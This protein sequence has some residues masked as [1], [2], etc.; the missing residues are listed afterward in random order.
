M[1]E[2]RVLLGAVV[3]PLA[4]AIIDREMGPDLRRRV[5]Q[6][7]ALGQAENA[8]QLA[9][10]VAQLRA[11][12]EQLDTLPLPDDAD[13]SSVGDQG[14]A[15]SAEVHGWLTTAEVAAALGVTDRQ[16]RHLEVSGR[17]LGQRVRARWLFDPVS[18][19]EERERRARIA[20]D[21]T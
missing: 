5:R 19:A 12:A 17:L 18:V 2:Q 8:R 10:A 6:L 13:G 7:E 11:A 1:S 4:A 20:A 16:V 21:Q 14:R 9:S 15:M 3:G